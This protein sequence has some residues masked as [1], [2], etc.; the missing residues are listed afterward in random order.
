VKIIGGVKVIQ[1]VHVLRN[2]E[3]M[4]SVQREAVSEVIEQ[5]TSL[6]LDDPKDRA[7]LARRIRYALGLD[8]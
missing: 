6:S 3:Q 7:V 4:R 5:S 2:A 8:T 1:R